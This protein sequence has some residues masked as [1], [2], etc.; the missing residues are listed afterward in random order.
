MLITDLF[1]L[2]NSTFLV[3][4]FWKLVREKSVKSQ[5]ISLSI[6]CGNPLNH[7]I[8]KGPAKALI[9]LRVCTGWSEPLLVA[10]TT[11]G[12]FMLW[13]IYNFVMVYVV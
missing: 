8:F 13:L 1:V 9:R 2:T 5:G 3:R 11:V 12:N 6:V 7:R 10:H 4:E